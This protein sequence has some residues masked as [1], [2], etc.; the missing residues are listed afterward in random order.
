VRCTAD[1]VEA[2]ARLVPSATPGAARMLADPSEI[3]LVIGKALVSKAIGAEG[4]V[5]I[6][7][8]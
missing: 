4:L 2:G 7:P 3:G 8:A 5:A 6:G 1:Q